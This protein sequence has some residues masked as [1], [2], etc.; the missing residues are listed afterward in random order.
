MSEEPIGYAPLQIIPVVQGIQAGIEGQIAQPLVAAGRSAG[1]ATGNAIVSGLAAAQAGVE[2]AAEALRTAREKEADAAGKV[3]VAEE[4]LRELRE[5][6]RASA[7]QLAR[8]EEA[9]A[10]A[11]RNEE[12]A[13][14]AT[15]RGVDQ[16][17]AAHRALENATGDA[18]EST[19][20]FSRAINSLGDR[21]GP[22]AKQMAAAA[23]AAAGIGTAMD[24]A[25]EAVSRE[26]NV[27][28][29]AAQL[30]ATPELAAEYGKI[31]GDLY[32]QGLGESFEDVTAAI[33][34]VQ[35][36]F[37]TL[38]SEGEASIEQ[39]TTRALNFATVFGTE[40][41]ESI[42]TASQLVKNGLAVD[43]TAAFDLMT[44][45]FQRVPA[46]MRDELPE[47]L[48]EYGTNLRAL[49]F[50]GQQAFGLLVDAA[51]QG[52][53]VL[54]KT[55][56]AL[57]EFTIRGSDMSQASQDAYKA[58]GLDAAEMSRAIAEGGPVAQDALQK[59]AAGLLEIEDP[60]ERANTSI[61]LFGTPLEDL[62]VDQ[63]PAFLG[64]LSGAG[65]SMTGFAGSADQMGETVANNTAS[66]L[67]VLKREIQ[68]GLLGALT[69]AA[70]WIDRNREV[71]VGL[72]IALGTLGAALVTA[73]VAATGYA[74]AQGVMA[75]STGAGT[76]ALAGNSLALGAY[77]IATGVVR[78]ATMAW[79]AVQWLLNA[80]LTA[81]PIGIVVVA[82][83]ALVAGVVLAYQKSET[84]RDIVKGAL[85]A[86]AGAGLWLWHNALEPFV[87]WWVG[88][89][90]SA[91]EA[92]TS[93]GT[94]A[95]EAKDFIIGKFTDLTTWLGDL[96]GQVTEKLSGLWNGLTTG[97][98]TALNSLISMWNNF[99]LTFDFTIPVI[100][101]H[102]NFTIDT[103]DLPLLA[104]GGIAGRTA[105]GLLWG[106]GTPTSDSILGIDEN[107]VPTARVSRGE[108]VVAEDAM[109]NGGAELVA[110]LNAGWVPPAEFLRNMVRGGA[111]LAHGNYDGSL[112]GVGLEEDSPIVAAVLGLR[113]LLH[114]GD[115]TGN[116][117]S[118]GVE[119]DAPAVS[120]ALGL[121]SLLLGDYDGRLAALGVEEDNPLVDLGLGVGGLLRGDYRGNLRAFGVEEDSP[122]VDAGLGLGGLLRG[123][124]TGNLSNLGLEEDHPLVAAAL[125]ALRFLAALPGFAD[126]GLVEA[127]N[128]VRGEDGKP[129]QYGGTGNP[130]WD[131]SGIAGGLWAKATG[132]NPNARYF[133]TESDFT[134]FGFLT[135][136]GGP[137]DLT[138]GV[139]RGGGGPNSHMASRI[140]DL[141][142]E[143]SGTDGV[144]VGSD[145][146]DPSA[147]P[148]QWHFPIPGNPLAEGNPGALGGLGGGAGS[149]PGGSTGG[150]SGSSSSS[151]SGATGG[152]RPNGPAV[153]VWVDNMP[154]NFG[155]TG[156]SAA[157]GTGAGTPGTTADAGAT[158]TGTPGADA[159][160]ASTPKQH[161]L[162]GTALTGDLFTGDAPWWQQN[163]PWEYLQTKGAEK[164][165]AT[166]KDA[167]T[168]FENNWKEMLN[169]GLAMLGMGATGAPA[170]APTFNISGT[171]PMGAAAA[172]DRVLRRRTLALQMGGGISR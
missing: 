143:S 61:A 156:S 55:G 20:R 68:D 14:R 86:V 42:Q 160:S 92:F 47:I 140:G 83:G 7:A 169:S 121:R 166:Q 136:P 33:G 155:G 157:T 167:T 17:A 38:G 54:D 111:R 105:A 137:G 4:K 21:L 113:S 76:A 82:I 85:D 41:P 44:T 165:Q 96:P 106:P 77:T 18:E 52:K 139:K 161:P 99:Q 66:K 24:T 49:G 110:A 46:A 45:A 84:F 151:A 53:F 98:K 36:G 95:G 115:F 101:K 3:R 27:D 59:V 60:A 118:L 142:V 64:A 2:R 22:A 30:G 100:D 109:R 40:V 171:D 146:T 172:V 114:D 75:A 73:K 107:G 134:Q 97:F 89:A 10:T 35:S 43:S 8:A 120:A 62:S 104:G 147:F 39:V 48:N 149:S 130:S 67:E 128:W 154:T 159:S 80:A 51:Q 90:Q 65:D 25:M 103:P 135:G 37:T 1:Q 162:Q 5:S 112:R 31:A 19:G 102:I 127:Q 91:W 123:D 119:E 69:G 125:D 15:Q 163:N 158:G 26:Q 131:C 153:L 148:L 28:I 79:S 74:V 72:G 122:L 144:E 57:K 94:K 13:A 145:A 81:N 71:A 32:K 150:G 93:I 138:I 133:N 126:G 88:A 78:G 141:K 70:E 116:L 164:W 63:I 16:L 168:Y 170:E 58:I 56:D 29:L 6:G 108:G 152:T 23:V 132:R 129:Y 117:S 12:R 9:L 124:Y 34:A 50:D 87:N 11:Q